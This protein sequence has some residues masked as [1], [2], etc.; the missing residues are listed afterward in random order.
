MLRSARDRERVRHDVP[1]SVVTRHVVGNREGSR[2]VVHVRLVAFDEPDPPFAVQRHRDPPD[3]E[4][5]RGREFFGRAARELL[6][7]VV[8]DPIDEVLLP[9]EHLRPPRIVGERRLAV[10]V[11]PCR[12]ECL[13][14]RGGGVL[15]QTMTNPDKHSVGEGQRVDRLD[16]EGSLSVAPGDAIA[17]QSAESA[18]LPAGN[19]D[20]VGGDNGV[21][22][23]A[24]S[25]VGAKDPIDAVW[26]GCNR[27]AP[28]HGHEL[29][30]CVSNRVKITVRRRRIASLPPGR[31]ITEQK[32]TEQINRNTRNYPGKVFCFH[33]C[34]RG[35]YAPRNHAHK[36]GEDLCLWISEASTINLT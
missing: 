23:G 31:D 27:V 12:T 6:E 20:A 14:V 10:L 2:P 11:Q 28:A 30:V 26:R 24:F 22:D 3:L 25:A 9:L 33:I 15:V 32:R 13:R 7:L 17:R 16:A 4:V 19:K 36:W 34:E 35:K 1:G 21:E 29:S 5:V 18:N 8:A